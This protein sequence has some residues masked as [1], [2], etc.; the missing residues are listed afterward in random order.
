[1]NRSDD[2]RLRRPRP[3]RRAAV[4]ALIGILLVTGCRFETVP[5]EDIEASI[6]TMLRRTAEAWNSGD[7]DGVMSFYADASSTALVT[8][9]GPVF[10]RAAI[11][12]VYEPWFRAGARRA[13]IRFEDIEVRTQP[14]LVGIV[15]GRRVREGGS[16]DP[17]SGW[18]TLVVRRVGNGWR[19]VHDH[20]DFVYTP[21]SNRHE[22]RPA[23]DDS[24]TDT[25]DMEETT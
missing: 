24:S 13:R 14:P 25:R 20:P 9:E 18:F 1:M 11:R 10:G 16:A 15:T 5:E 6:E 3:G 8:P 7:L 4:P 21:I 22:V 19:I 17:T 2:R 23:A 12:A